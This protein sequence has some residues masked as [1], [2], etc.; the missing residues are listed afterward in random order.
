MLSQ[1]TSFL[2]SSQ[3]YSSAKYSQLIRI[4]CFSHGVIRKGNFS[5]IL[6]AKFPL[7]HKSSQ[8]CPISLC[9]EVVI[10]CQCGHANEHPAALCPLKL[11]LGIACVALCCAAIIIFL[12]CCHYCFLSSSGTGSPNPLNCLYKTQGACTFLVLFPL[13]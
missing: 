5:H 13:K 9:P 8:F 7:T 6:Q 1:E 3:N 2:A 4:F 12:C 11:L 10:E